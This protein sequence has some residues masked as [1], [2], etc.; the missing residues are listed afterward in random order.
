MTSLGTTPVGKLQVG[1]N[2]SGRSYDVTL[3]DVSVSTP[4]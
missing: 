3:D 4:G 2:I 1:E